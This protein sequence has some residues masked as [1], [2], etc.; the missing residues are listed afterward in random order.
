M[1]DVELISTTEETWIWKCPGGRNHQPHEIPVNRASA[2]PSHEGIMAE[3]GLF[4]DLPTCLLPDEGWVEHGVVEYR[5]K[6]RFPERYSKLV[7]EYGH[8][9][10][11]GEWE[12][13]ASNLI[14]RALEILERR[15]GVLA[16]RK[17][18]GRA[19]GCFSD[20]STCGYWALRPGPAGGVITTWEAYAKGAGLDPEVWVI[21]GVR[22]SGRRP[23]PGSRHRRLAA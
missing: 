16:Q 22:G 17:P 3:A 10:L 14:A 12:S 9:M 23:E 13:S 11:P 2:A 21:P 4:A 15:D 20:N 1:S 6:E 8:R 19:T 7:A 5:Y 18:K